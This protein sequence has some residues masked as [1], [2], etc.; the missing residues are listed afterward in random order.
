MR[1]AEEIA[2]LIWNNNREARVPDSHVQLIKSYAREVAD[3]Q[4]LEFA[5][6]L[7][8]EHEYVG[9]DQWADYRNQQNISGKQL[10]NKYHEH[11]RK[12]I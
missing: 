1:T 3:A 7:D 5:K 11:L 10:I 4:S 12:N 2:Q 8:K 6:W 9:D